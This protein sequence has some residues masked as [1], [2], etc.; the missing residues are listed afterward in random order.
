M[1]SYFFLFIAICGEI[2]A[3]SA[4]KASVGFSRLYPSL[5]AVLG[6][7]AAFYFLSLSMRTIPVGVA[8][9]IWAGV[10]IVLVTIVG[11]VLF[12]QQ[13]NL[14]TIA[15]IGMILVGV[16]MVSLCA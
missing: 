6:Y 16:L 13:L 12:G 11:L 8:Y 9:A 10:G 14:P 5:M 7:G 3:T 15:G 1:Q 2:A 4:L